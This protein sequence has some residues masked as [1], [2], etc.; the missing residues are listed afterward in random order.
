MYY[1]IAGIPGIR[2]LA[3]KDG[4]NLAVG[5]ELGVVLL[6]DIRTNKPFASKDHMYGLPIKRVQFLSEQNLIFSMDSKILKIWNY[7]TSKPYTSIQTQKDLNDLC[8]VPNTGM[9][10]LACEDKKIQS[11]FIPSLGSA[12]KWCSFLDSIVEELEENQEDTIYDDYKFVTMKDLEKI[13]LT[14]LVGTNLLRAYMHGFFIDHRL[15]NKAQ[16]VSNPFAYEEYKKKKI[17]QVMEDKAGDRVKLE[18]KLPKVNRELARKLMEMELTAEKSK[19]SRSSLVLL[20]D[21]R[22][23]ALFENPDYQIEDEAT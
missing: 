2:S 5:T 16:A 10:F 19:K 8:I 12:P 3:W 14:H 22:F 6:Y 4:M 7:E 18:S 11:F 1:F 20:K 21:D 13:G 9:F 17:K 15:Y 23:K